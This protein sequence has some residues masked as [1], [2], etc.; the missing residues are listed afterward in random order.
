MEQRSEP[1]RR[2]VVDGAPARLA[3]FGAALALVFTAG[4]AVGTLTG[5]GD[6]DT[7]PAPTA[8][9]QGHDTEDGS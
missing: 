6:D 2:S 5:G 1:A 7:T 9:H 4:F 8:P 3:A